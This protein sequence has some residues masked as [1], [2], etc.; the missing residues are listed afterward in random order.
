MENPSIYPFVVSVRS[1]A[2]VIRREFV[3]MNSAQMF[4]GL[5]LMQ[6]TA[7]G[8]YT[9]LIIDANQ[10]IAV[11]EVKLWIEKGAVRSHATILLKEPEASK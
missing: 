2:E 8:L 1:N 9:M 7:P 5:C 11:Q 3:D 4:L 10:Q 6:A